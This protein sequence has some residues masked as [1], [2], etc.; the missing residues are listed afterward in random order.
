MQRG[1]SLVELSIVLVILGLLTGGILAGQSLIRASELRSLNADIQRY[2]A[3]SNTFR[4]KYFALPGDMTNATRFWGRLNGNADCVSTHGG[5]VATPGACD[6][7]GDGRIS[8]A[9][10][11]S[12]AGEGWGFWQQLAHAGL[13]EGNYT[14]LAGSSAAYPG[15]HAILGINAPRAKLSNVGFSIEYASGGSYG[16]ANT[17]YLYIGVPDPA[18]G[19]TWN[20][21]L[22]SEEMWNVDV[23]TDDGRPGTGKVITSHSLVGSCVTTNVAATAEYKLDDTGIPCHIY[24]VN[25]L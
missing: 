11:A 16:I 17:N 22:K 15:R 4:D 8:M 9:A 21:F 7:N 3:A 25:F 1:F 13:I 20:P 18:G 14:G 19:P 2:M 6:G 24:L 23:K 10:A 5:A 12:Q